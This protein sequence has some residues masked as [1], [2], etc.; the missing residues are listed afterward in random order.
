MS[1]FRPDEPSADAS[2]GRKR[3]I[4]GATAGRV[5]GMT[6]ADRERR[7]IATAHS[8]ARAMIAVGIAMTAVGILSFVTGRYVMAWGTLFGVAMMA[9]GAV[10]LG[11]ARRKLAAL[12]A[13]AP[14]APTTAR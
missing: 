4:C 6:E 14:A 13:G 12:D 8:T 11:S 3:L 5:S 7:R 1:R 10:R 2:S 9:V